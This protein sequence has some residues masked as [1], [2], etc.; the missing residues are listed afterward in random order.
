MSCGRVIALRCVFTRTQ[1]R[2]WWMSLGSFANL[3]LSRL[4]C[5]LRFAP[6]TGNRTGSRRACLV[7]I[8]RNRS[9]GIAAVGFSP[10]LAEVLSVARLTSGLMVNLSRLSLPSL[11]CLMVLRPVVSM[12]GLSLSS[13]GGDLVFPVGFVMGKAFTVS[14]TVGLVSSFKTLRERI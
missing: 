6:A 3:E 11:P 7:K 1:V 2:R 14:S 10:Q 8:G 13:G 12:P 4:V 5:G 9:L